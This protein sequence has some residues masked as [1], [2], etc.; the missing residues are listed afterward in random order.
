MQALGSLPRLRPVF[1][2]QPDGSIG[3]T[4]QAPQ[5]DDPLTLEDALEGVR[6]VKRARP[7]ALVLDEFQDVAEL[8]DAET[9]YAVVRAAMQLAQG[10]GYVFCGSRRPLLTHSFQ[11]S[12]SPLFKSVVTL[13]INPVEP[14]ELLPSVETL[15]ASGTRVVTRAQLDE[16][17]EMADGITSDVQQLCQ[18]IWTLTDKGD[19]IDQAVL[20]HAVNRVLD[21]QRVMYEDW[22]RQLTALQFTVVC[23]LAHVGGKEV[24]GNA[25]LAHARTRNASS[26]R[27]VLTRFA[28]RDLVYVEN[29]AYRFVHPFFREWLRR[30]FPPDTPSAT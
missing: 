27:R 12:E 15:F 26:V 20:T 6:R 13:P 1:Q 7:L 11:H 3:V 14:D 25:F 2:P 16:I 5:R 9:L 17:Y 28:E 8:R 23:A 18:M 29:G 24:Y 21:A 4:F 19:V 22:I 10:I 30:T